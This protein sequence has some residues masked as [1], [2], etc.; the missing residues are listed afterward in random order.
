MGV[1][2]C[3]GNVMTEDHEERGEKHMKV[4]V[5]KKGTYKIRKSGLMCCPRFAPT[6]RN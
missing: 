5:V 6:S 2:P 4:I 1:R 3:P